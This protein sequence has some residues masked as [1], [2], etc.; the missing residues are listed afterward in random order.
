MIV[1]YRGQEIGDATLAPDGKLHVLKNGNEVPISIEMLKEIE[2]SMEIGTE[3]NRQ[4][5][6]QPAQPHP[7]KWRGIIV[8]GCND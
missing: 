2:L 8:D 3:F 5:Q 7:T 6:P 1:T 4:P